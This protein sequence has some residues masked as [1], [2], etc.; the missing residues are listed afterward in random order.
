MGRVHFFLLRNISRSTGLIHL[1]QAQ[2][3]KEMGVDKAL[4][5]RGIKQLLEKNILR[6]TTFHNAPVFIM[7]PN[8]NKGFKRAK[9]L[10]EE[11]SKAKQIQV[12]QLSQ[13][14]IQRIRDRIARGEE[15]DAA[16]QAELSK[17]KNDEVISEVEFVFTPEWDA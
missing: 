2:I 9:K 4:V 16:L 11:A 13:A 17:V 15:T 7:H 8:V 12:E 10:W 3:A 14:I 5:S 1:T 6:K